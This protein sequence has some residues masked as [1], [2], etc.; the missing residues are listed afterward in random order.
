MLLAINSPLYYPQANAAILAPGDA[1]GGEFL[2]NTYTT[3]AQWFPSIAI[4]ADGDF[5]IVWQSDGQDGSS[6]GIVAQRYNAD[7]S[8]AGGEL[9]VNT[10]TTSNQRYASIA[11]DADG[12]FVIVWESEGQ[13]GD[14]YGVVAQRYN[15][16][17]T[18]V[19]GEL[20]VN[21]YTTSYQGDASIAMDADGDFVVAWNSY[22]QDGDSWGI[23]A[24][25]YNADGTKVGGELAVNT[26]T[27]SYQGNAN[28]AMDAD[29]HFVVVWNS[30]GQD[31]SSYGIVAQ[32]YNAD[33]TKVGGELA[34]NTV[35]TSEQSRPSIAMDA[36]GD[37]VVAW[38]SKGQDGDGNGIYAQRYN[39]DGS[40]AGIEFAVNTVT[41]SEQ[42][43]PSIALDADGDF[44]VAWESYGQ[45]GD[46]HGIYAQRYNADGSKAGVEFAVNTVTNDYQNQPSIALDA[47]G[48][49][50]VVWNS[51]VQDG[52][53]YGVYA[54]RYAGVGETV[55][56]NQVVT[57]N[58]GNIAGTVPH[59]VNVVD[60]IVPVIA[61]QGDNPKKVTKDMEF[62][63]VATTASDNIGGDLSTGTVVTDS[64]DSAT[65][66]SHILSSD[67]TDAAG[68]AAATVTRTVEVKAAGV[69][70]FSLL[71]ALPIWLRRRFKD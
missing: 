43:R 44:V 24:Q 66:G 12:D 41:T 64:V 35:T 18:K 14:N 31:G 69:G 36:D 19:G 17:G 30:F 7:G 28:I 52:S 40:K 54:Q 8:K 5:V 16:D 42:S 9:A 68:N 4:D 51:Y 50:V 57:D 2:V 10:Y 11:M 38:E 53:N 45:D 22:D 25:R 61:L 48:G 33:G 37:F 34:V 71:L 20:A 62:S 6:N 55:D 27:T 32:R 58:A 47:D 46:R 23:Y 3:G 13:D 59:T 63:N 49:F 65:K 26:Y 70:V 67:V 15:A 21:T 56:P 39:A 60:E 1:V 29:G